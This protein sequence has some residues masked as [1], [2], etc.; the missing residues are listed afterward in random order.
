V[1]RLA[2]LVA[3][4]ACASCAPAGEATV[5]RAPTDAAAPTTSQRGSD[6]AR[7]PSEAAPPGAPDAC[8][9]PWTLEGMAGGPGRAVV[10]CGHD[11]RRAE[12]DADMARAI[13]PAL[14]PARVRVCACA[15]KMHA[16][17]HVDLVVTAVPA[18]GRATVR[19]SQD[20]VDDVDPDLGPPFAACVGVVSVSFAPSHPDACPAGEEP[21]LVYPAR[22][23]LA[24]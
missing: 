17:A 8:S 15:A 14:D 16:P 6:A 13:A 22:I 4:V 10:V 24:P 1:R 7:R 18:Q 3:L 20:D 5:V 19:V 9:Q 2:P 23:D 11:V 21:S 12:L